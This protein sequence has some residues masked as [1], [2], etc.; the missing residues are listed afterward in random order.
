MKDLKVRNLLITKKAILTISFACFLTGMLIGG[1][2]V[3]KSK[4]PKSNSAF[5]LIFFGILLWASLIP[6]L[7]KQIKVMHR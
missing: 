2:M 1:L 4:D 3:F 5:I 6:I 7:R